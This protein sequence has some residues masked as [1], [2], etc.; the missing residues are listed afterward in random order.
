MTQSQK[1]ALKL[2][3]TR[4]RI[5]ELLQIAEAELTD[6]QR[7]ELTAKTDEYP[8]LETR[9]RAECVAEDVAGD[10]GAHQQTAEE[11]EYSELVE[12]ASVGDVFAA[13]VSH[14]SAEGAT[15]ELQLEGKLEGNQVPLDLIAPSARAGDVV[16]HRLVTPAP[17]NVGAVQHP[18]TGYVFPNGA[19]AFLGVQQPRVGVGEQV[20]PVLTTAPT[21]AD[22]DEAATVDETTGAFSADAL[23][24][25][26]LQASFFYSREDAARF[27]DMDTSLRQALTDGLSDGLDKAVI[28]GATAG[29]LGANGVAARAGDAGAEA[30]FVIYRALL[31]DSATIDGRYAMEASD[32]RL[33]FGAASYAHAATKYRGNSADDS[34]IDSLMAKA[35]GVRVSAHVPAVAAKDQSLVV[36]K[37]QAMD[38]VAP[39]WEGVTIIPDEVTKAAT[40]EIVLTAVMLHAVKVLRADGFIHRKV[41]VAA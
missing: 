28:A 16:E 24:P 35:G 25:R 8:A 38:A 40:G 34:A 22:A 39:I 7:A 13:A 12:R 11:R 30:T 1:L 9:W 32:V 20:Y 14:R 21:V 5:N 36:R 18:V 37:G 33:L 3:E 41:Q 31:F 15:A 6:E 10:A 27:R 19:A 23:V 26:R 2:S 29:I 17:A 4:Q